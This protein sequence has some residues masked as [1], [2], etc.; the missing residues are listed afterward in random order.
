M[1]FDRDILRILFRQLV[2][3]GSHVQHGL[4]FFGFLL[5]LLIREPFHIGIRR[6][7]TISVQDKNVRQ[8]NLS[9]IV[10]VTL[11]IISNRFLAD[12]G[13][14]FTRILLVIISSG[15]VSRADVYSL[16]AGLAR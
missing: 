11:I 10:Q 9:E 15:F 8:A 2:P 14:D 7:G 13:S 4:D 16:P 3:V 12:R 6:Y 5:G 1:V